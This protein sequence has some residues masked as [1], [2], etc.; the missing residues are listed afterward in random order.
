MFLTF[1]SK[2]PSGP[3]DFGV[4]STRVRLNEN[5]R[6]EFV[7]CFW[8]SSP[9]LSIVS[10]LEE[11][12]CRFI[13]FEPFGVQSAVVSLSDI[14]PVSGG[15][16]IVMS[17]HVLQGIS[18]PS[19]E[20]KVPEPSAPYEPDVIEGNDG[21]LLED[22]KDEGRDK[23]EEDKRD[24][25]ADKQKSLIDRLNKLFEN[26]LNRL[27]KKIEKER[28]EREKKERATLQALVVSISKTINEVLPRQIDDIVK[29]RV[30]R[31]LLPTVQNQIDQS[32]AKLASSMNKMDARTRESS[33]KAVKEALSADT[34]GELL[35]DVFQGVNE[36]HVRRLLLPAYQKSFESL[37]TQL[38]GMLE[39]S[40]TVMDSR[41]ASKA[42]EQLECMSGLEFRIHS[43]EKK[44]DQLIT[45]LN[46]SRPTE[47]RSTDPKAVVTSLLE[48]K[49]TNEAFEEVLNIET[50]EMVVW[51]CEKI[52]ADVWQVQA[53][54]SGPV[55]LSLVHRLSFN[56]QTD[57][58]LKL[59]W[60]AACLNTLLSRKYEDISVERHIKPVLEEVQERF[61]SQKGSL[62]EE[63]RYVMY[64]VEH[65]LRI[66]TS[67]S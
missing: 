23:V 35:R 65:S 57:S 31:V 19:E 66:L 45:E 22:M 12:K 9:V 27:Y 59:T 41:L 1:A 24:D 58:L 34:I 20:A 33:E 4:I 29:D 6:C 61:S 2:V 48:A 43:L 64:G 49:R 53:S 14:A 47:G 3:G 13:L 5:Y 51:L 8:L 44:F 17:P 60:L 54:L 11:D 40:L 32:F 15:G 30:E 42:G 10:C 36:V 7:N 55:L 39:R 37:F 38:N 21:R 26:H 56:L 16:R 18:I 46:T 63:S 25:R 50:T 62:P 67:A 28:V 52:E